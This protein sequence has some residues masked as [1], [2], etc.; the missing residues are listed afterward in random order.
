M[1]RPDRIGDRG[2]MQVQLAGRDLVKQK[3]LRFGCRVGWRDARWTRRVPLGLDLTARSLPER[4]LT[5]GIIGSGADG[6]SCRGA[7]LRPS[8]RPEPG[9]AVEQHRRPVAQREHRVV[10]PPGA[11]AHR[12]VR[13]YIVPTRRGSF[14]RR[15]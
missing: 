11:R 1:T 7:R 8:A 5:P 13:G 6:W 10:P 9:I 2:Q 3:A 4:L 14:R 12:D 15:H